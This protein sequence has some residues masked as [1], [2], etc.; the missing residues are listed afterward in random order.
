MEVA[1]GTGLA[2]FEI[3]RRNPHGTNTGIDLSQGMLAVAEKRL[4]ALPEASYTLC[5]G[6]A[7]DLQV[8]DGS[9][10][11]LMNNYLF[12]L[13]PFEEMDRVLT[14]FWRVLKVGGRLI[15]V[16]MTA[17]EGFG[18]RIY[19][20]IYRRSPG[21]MGGCRGVKMASRLLQQGFRVELR[22][23]HQQLLFPSE[24]IRAWKGGE[25]V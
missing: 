15:L 1:V 19:E 7:F 23:Y 21:L 16:N 18:S 4:S 10:D 24:V 25:A 14:E 3:V 13:I 2:F 17:G 12:D 22:E 11:V 5:V 20:R 6:T 8:A 9:I